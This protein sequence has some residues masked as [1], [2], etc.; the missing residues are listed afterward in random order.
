MRLP[1]GD[2]TGAEIIARIEGQPRTDAPREVYHVDVPVSGL[3]ITPRH[4]D[5]F[6]VGRQSGTFILARRPDRAERL[7]RAIQPGQLPIVG[8]RVRI[9]DQAAIVG[10]GKASKLRLD[11][12][13]TTKGSPVSF[14][15]SASKGAASKAP[16]RAKS[17]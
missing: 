3:R 13:A 7:A 14:R 1:S 2:Q 9:V 16:A 6:P 15:L 11:L 4:R 8:E 5:P 17:R 12:S 10:D